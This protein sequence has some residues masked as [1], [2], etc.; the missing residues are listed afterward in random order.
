[1]AAS[2]NLKA[3]P[4]ENARDYAGR[5]GRPMGPVVNAA[6]AMIEKHIPHAQQT[7]KWGWLCWVGNGNVISIIVLRKYVNLQFWRGA[8]L[9]G[10]GKILKG[11]GK[12]LRHIRLT[13]AADARKP[14]VIA[15]LKAARQA[16]GA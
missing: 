14:E 7:V 13:K 2:K 12:D 15:M 1:M 8:H 9:P 5:I 3:Q 6:V 11:T 16:D 4:D 10:G